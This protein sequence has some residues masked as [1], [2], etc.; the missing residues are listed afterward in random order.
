MQLIFEFCDSAN[1]PLA[2]LPIS[3]Q[4][5]EDRLYQNHAVRLLRCSG[6]NCDLRNEKTGYSHDVQALLQR[7]WMTWKMFQRVLLQVYETEKRETD[8]MSDQSSTSHV[9]I[10]P[11]NLDD[12]SSQGSLS[13]THLGPK[14]QIPPKLLTGP[15]SSEQTH[16]LHYLTWLR[17]GIDWELSVFGE[18]A[19]EGLGQAIRERSRLAVA[20][21]VCPVIGVVP[22]MANLRSAV[23]D[24]GCDQTI[25]FHL[26]NA[27]MRSHILSRSDGQSASTSTS[28]NFRDPS[29]WS[30]AGRVRQANGNKSSWL[31]ETLKY[32]GDISTTRSSYDEHTY[33]DFVRACGQERDG[34]Q[35]VKVPLIV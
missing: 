20:T 18:A 35:V 13:Y 7:R 11:P 15:W 9:S 6:K 32:A 28:V 12:P 14:L 29:L 3:K 1:L 10:T 17:L 16:F 4:L 25:V 30:W 23:V 27:A 8:H 21:L 22:S 19:I 34:V 26:L 2:S 24:Y 33:Q 5:S 31:K